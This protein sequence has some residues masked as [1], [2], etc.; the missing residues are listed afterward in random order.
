MK[1]LGRDSREF[2]FKTAGCWFNDKD[3]FSSDQ[4]MGSWIF[5]FW[6]GWTWQS[7]GV[8]ISRQPK[9]LGCREDTWVETSAS[10]ELTTTVLLLGVPETWTLT[11]T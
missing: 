3:H 4:R 8:W 5:R 9:L 6:P 11:A 1:R 2:T 10:I 7:F